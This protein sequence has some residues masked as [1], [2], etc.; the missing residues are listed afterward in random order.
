MRRVRQASHEYEPTQVRQAV[1]V[2]A[3]R[4]VLAAQAVAGGD[5]AEALQVHDV[6][7]ADVVAAALQVVAPVALLPEPAGEDL[8]PIPV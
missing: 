7:R 2:L 1:G 8:A 6:Q 4:L 5:A 3:E